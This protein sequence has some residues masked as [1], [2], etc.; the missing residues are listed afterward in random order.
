M[1]MS[2]KAMGIRGL[3]VVMALSLAGC[4][5]EETV[6]QSENSVADTSQRS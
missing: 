4:E 2:K 5:S 6:L 1:A 3:T